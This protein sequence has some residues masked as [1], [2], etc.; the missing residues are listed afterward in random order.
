MASGANGDGDI[1]SGPWR[2]IWFTVGACALGLGAIGVVLPLLPTTPFVLLAA[3]AF[4][5]SSPRLARWLE[6]SRTFGPSILRWR[7]HRAIAPRTKALAVAVMAGVFLA[8]VIAAVSATVLIVQA[9]CM[10]G[11][12]AFIL[13][14]PNGP[15]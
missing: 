6:N 10:A 13:S 5:K 9:V 3:F 1:G 14:R 2:A 8:S 11:A 7:E 4:G 15:S 12:A